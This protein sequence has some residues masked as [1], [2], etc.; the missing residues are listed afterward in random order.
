V[1]GTC[2]AIAVVVREP[3]A[4][5]K[6]IG[7]DLRVER[8][9]DKTGKV[10]RLHGGWVEVVCNPCHILVVVRERGGVVVGVRIGFWGR[11]EFEVVGIVCEFEV[12]CAAALGVGLE[13][14][15]ALMRISCTGFGESVELGCLLGCC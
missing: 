9:W 10:V 2:S 3:I 1:S 8:L 14:G 12:V 15:L 7:I 13:V 5:I 4:E 6:D 11:F